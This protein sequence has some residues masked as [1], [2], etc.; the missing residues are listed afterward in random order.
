MKK[1]DAS[2]ISIPEKIQSPA[3]GN[4]H[5]NRHEKWLIRT[6]LYNMRR[7]NID[8]EQAVDQTTVDH[9]KDKTGKK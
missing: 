2:D 9:E 7:K 1:Y 8:P 6:R 4:Q 5:L 3:A